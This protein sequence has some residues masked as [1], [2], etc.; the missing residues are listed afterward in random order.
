MGDSPQPPVKARASVFWGRFPDSLDG[1]GQAGENGQSFVRTAVRTGSDR[2]ILQVSSQL[3]LSRVRYRLG[4]QLVGSQCIKSMIRPSH[5]CVLGSMYSQATVTRTIA[6][7]EWPAPLIWCGPL[8]SLSSKVNT[9]A[10]QCLCDQDEWKVTPGK[11][12]AC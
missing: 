7:R 11:H 4:H 3:I 1:A 8:Y 6:S 10:K 12:R 9:N 2:R 5:G